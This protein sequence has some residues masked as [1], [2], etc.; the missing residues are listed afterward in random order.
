M[1][2]IEGIKKSAEKYLMHSEP[3]IPRKAIDLQN[4]HRNK[5]IMKK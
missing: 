4:N 5:P 3:H 1:L 2:D